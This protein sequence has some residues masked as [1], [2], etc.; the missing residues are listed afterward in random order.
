LEEPLTDTEK[1][2]LRLLSKGLSN[3]EIADLMEITLR[4]VKFHTGNLY[5][6]MNVKSRMQAIQRATDIL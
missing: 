3:D 6:K 4:T 1:S 2:V 5:A